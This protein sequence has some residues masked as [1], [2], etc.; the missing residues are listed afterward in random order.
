MFSQHSQA[1]E[2]G[3]LSTELK[4]GQQRVQRFPVEENRT[5][6][7]KGKTVLKTNAA[8]VIFA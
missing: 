3:Q 7:V 2:T 1:I 4:L 6:T 5:C 8:E